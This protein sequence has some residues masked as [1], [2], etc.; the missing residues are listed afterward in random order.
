VVGKHINKIF[1]THDGFYNKPQILCH[2]I[3]KAFSNQLARVLNC[4]LDFQVLV[5]VG[6]YLQFSFAYPLS[7][8]LNN[9]LD[10]KIVRNAEFFQSRPDCK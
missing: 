9:A 4:K 1:L 10:F 3:T 6:I 2:G 8:I 5:P 7:V